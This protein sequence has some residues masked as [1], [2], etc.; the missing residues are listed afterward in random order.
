M[1][2]DGQARSGELVLNHGRTET[3]A[4][5]PV[6][7]NATV[8]AM[9]VEDLDAL[10]VRLILGNTYHL[11]L[12]P[13]I[14]VIKEAGGLHRFMSWPHAILT[15]SGGFQIFSLAALRRLDEEGVSFRSHI[16]GASHRLTPERVV[17]LQCDLGSDIMMALDICTPPDAGREA[18]EAACARTTRWAAR[19]LAARR[20]VRDA[21]AGALFAVVQ[22]NFYE[23]LRERS[24]SDLVAMD[25]SGYAV[26]GLSVGESAETY[27]DFLRLSV[28]FLPAEKPRY[29]MGIG[30]PEYVLDAI[31]CGV[32]LFDCV[33]PTRTARNALALT[34]DGTLSLRW[35]ENRL[36]GR[37]ID[38]KCPCPVCGSYSRSY[39]RH[40][41]KAKEILA[42]MLTTYHNLFFMQE[43]IQE[44]RAAIRERRFEAFKTGFLSRYRE[45]RVREGGEMTARGIDRRIGGCGG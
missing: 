10:G 41:F 36:D 21:A 22:G 7:T 15:D 33:Y 37:P 44:A 9:R 28:G 45:R 4:F 5:M 24:A 29:V 12:R 31:S 23:D 16:D 11:A 6:G 32:D 8:K 43:L 17:E 1:S 18:A 35:H 3:P 2:R 26:G 39:L 20:A 34:R 38:P 40:L 14:D 25:F 13:G 19:A 30:T 27:R 42:P